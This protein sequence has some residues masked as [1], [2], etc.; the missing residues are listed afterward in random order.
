MLKYDF[1][2]SIGY[3]VITVARDYERAFNA[4]LVPRGITWRQAQVLGWL[5]AED[6][7]TQTELADRMGI[8]A[9]TLVGILDRMERDGWISRNDC[10]TDRRK[11]I[12]RAREQAEPIWE[13]VMTC[14]QQVRAR[15][16]AGFTAAQ[17]DLLIDMLRQ[18]QDNLRIDVREKKGVEP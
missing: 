17:R 7:L 12:V 11:K 1:E 9:P 6:D 4:A 13:E 5:A 3:W 15:A 16:L 14:A 18:V 10:P 8:E 2:N